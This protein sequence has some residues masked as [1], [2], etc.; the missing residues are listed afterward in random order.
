MDGYLSGTPIQVIDNFIS[1]YD[2]KNCYRDLSLTEWRV[3][4]DHQWSKVT[5]RAFGRGIEHEALEVAL[6]ENEMVRYLHKLVKSRN[7]EGCGKLRQFYLNCI[8]P[9]DS[10]EYH[11]DVTPGKV[12][13][14]GST[15]LIYMN[16]VW[17]WWWGSGTEFLLDNKK[18]RLVRPKPGRA[19]IF[20]AAMQHRAVAPNILL[21]DFGRLSIALQFHK[22]SD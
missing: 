5:R 1:I 14:A 13:L 12:E 2:V 18:T 15:V 11:Q 9:G 6:K 19:I 20:P 21:N 10:F 16:P 8:K 17:K 22:D 4:Y 3:V 7:F